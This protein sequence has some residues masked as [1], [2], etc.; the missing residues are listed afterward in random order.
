MSLLSHYLFI[1]LTLEQGRKLSKE[2]V[3]R[4]GLHFG[5]TW[6]NEIKESLALLAEL[7]DDPDIMEWLMLDKETLGGSKGLQ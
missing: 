2:R 3:V 6:F 7:K 4:D 5:M 1:S